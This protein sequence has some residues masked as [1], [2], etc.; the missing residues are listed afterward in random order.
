VLNELD[1][2]DVLSHFATSGTF[3]NELAEW[4]DGAVEGGREEFARWLLGES[5]E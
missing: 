5:K 4:L 3:H 1:V 2:E